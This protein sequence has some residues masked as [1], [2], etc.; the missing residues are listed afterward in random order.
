MA[1]KSLDQYIKFL[2]QDIGIEPH[3]FSRDFDKDLS[4]FAFGDSYENDKPLAIQTLLKKG[5]NQRQAE[6]LID[7]YATKKSHYD[8]ENLARYFGKYENGIELE[9]AQKLARELKQAYPKHHVLYGLHFDGE[10]MNTAGLKKPLLL[11]D[12]QLNSLTHAFPYNK[13]G[14]NSPQKATQ[15]QFHVE[16]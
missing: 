14:D 16:H 3:F 9:D 8:G 7:L 11:D 13:K 4:A 12:E 6:D 5:L 10:D 2:S 1:A 15:F